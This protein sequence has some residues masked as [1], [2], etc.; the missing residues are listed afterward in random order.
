MQYNKNWNKIEAEVPDLITA[1]L[2]NK[3]VTKAISLHKT[4]WFN[5]INIFLTKEKRLQS[6]DTQP[7]LIIATK[8]A[9]ARLCS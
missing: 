9:Q 1:K 6:G 5:Q 4:V 2:F 8:E 7:A 3:T